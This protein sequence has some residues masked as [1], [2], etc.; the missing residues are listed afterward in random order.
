MMMAFPNSIR[1]PESA[2]CPLEIEMGEN[3]FVLC[4][5][6]IVAC[7]VGAAKSAQAKKG[8]GGS[9]LI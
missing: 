3:F 7:E 1:G 6:E 8:N 9:T 5:G 4:L 2:S